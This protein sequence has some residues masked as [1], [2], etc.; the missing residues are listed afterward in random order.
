[1]YVSGACLAAG[2]RRCWARRGVTR[3]GRVF[4][5]ALLAGG[6]PTA[7]RAWTSMRA[8]SLDIHV[9]MVVAV[10]G[11]SRCGDYF[12][13]ATV[14]FLFALAQWLESYSVDRARRAIRR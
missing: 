4:R 6:I 12:E 13:A 7:R 10:A 5:A 14:V 2:A 9:L 1:M 8:R 3:A 11:P